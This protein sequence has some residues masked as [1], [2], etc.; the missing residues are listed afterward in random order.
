MDYDSL[1][2][3]ELKTIC[4]ERGLRVSGSKAEVVIRLMEDDES[5]SPQSVNINPGNNTPPP[6]QVTQI[7][8][9]NNNSTFPALFGG[10]IIL[11]GLFRV[12]Y[13]FLWNFY[14]PLHSVVGIGIGLAFIF[15]GV[16]VIQGYKM[17]LKIA[18][19]I[20][21]FSGILSLIYINELTPLSAG[22]GGGEG[23]VG[24]S[25]LCSSF[26]ILTV[27]IP[28]LTNENYFRDGKPDYLGGALDTLDFFSP[29]PITNKSTIVTEN[30]TEVKVATTCPKCSTQLKIPQSYKGKAQC[31][32][33]KET[34]EVN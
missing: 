28:L 22:L 1:T 8:V 10:C 5:K 12:G 18:L 6:P 14:S 34:F 15:A 23:S 11:Y 16:I 7:Y 32:S 2:L 4:K 20:L 33:C 13:S 25:L 24:L 17:G 30:K 31:P 9:T 19:G 3:L 27:G 26:C 29:L 21:I